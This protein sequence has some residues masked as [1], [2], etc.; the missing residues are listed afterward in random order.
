MQIQGARHEPHV[1]AHAPLC[2]CV[3]RLPERHADL[4]VRDDAAQFGADGISGFAH[5]VGD[6]LRHG[7]AGTNGRGQ[8]PDRIGELFVPAIREALAASTAADPTGSERPGR[9]D[10]PAERPRE[11]QSDAPDREGQEDR[12]R[13][14]VDPRRALTTLG[15]ALGIPQDLTPAR[16]ARGPIGAEGRE[17]EE[18]DRQRAQ[19]TSSPT[20][21]SSSPRSSP[22]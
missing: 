17:T 18:R 9:S 22:R 2:P 10:E 13:L 12:S 16:G 6:R 15:P 5:R 21:N 11:H 8:R 19:P 20:A 3:D 7:H 14:D 4:D 1:A